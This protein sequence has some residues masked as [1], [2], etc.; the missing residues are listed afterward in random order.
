MTTTIKSAL[1]IGLLSASCLAA[2]TGSVQADDRLTK[3]L[4]IQTLNRMASDAAPTK[5]NRSNDDSTRQN[6]GTD[7]PQS[8]PQPYNRGTTGTTGST[9]GR[10]P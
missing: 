1:T 9:P 10:Q 7:R 6:Q 5:K 4:Q 8:Q 3:L 2:T